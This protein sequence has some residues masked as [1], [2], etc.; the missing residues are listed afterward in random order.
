M[1]PVPKTGGKGKPPGMDDLEW[2][3][4]VRDKYLPMDQKYADALERAGLEPYDVRQPYGGIASKTDSSGAGV[5]MVEDPRWPGGLETSI[6]K[7]PWEEYLLPRAAA[8]ERVLTH[9]VMSDTQRRLRY[10]NLLGW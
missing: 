2:N 5:F 6:S 7:R 1:R 9:P 8:D 3:I 10:L 4:Q